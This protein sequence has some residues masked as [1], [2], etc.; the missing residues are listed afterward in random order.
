MQTVKYSR[1]TVFMFAEKDYLLFCIKLWKIFFLYLKRINVNIPVMLNI[2][3]N[4][5]ANKMIKMNV[6]ICVC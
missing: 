5:G 4:D 3:S 6:T 2:L 1:F